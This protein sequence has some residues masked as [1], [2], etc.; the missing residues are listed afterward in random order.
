[1]IHKPGVEEVPGYYGLVKIE[2][3]VLQ[4]IWMEQDFFTDSLNTECGKEINLR[5][6]GEWNRSERGPSFKNARVEINGE[7]RSGDIEIHFHPTEWEE[8]EH[9]LDENF[10]RVVLHV[11]IFANSL[12]AKSNVWRKDKQAV[13][14]LYLLPYLFYGL[15]EYAEAQAL[16]QLS[17][18]D[19]FVEQMV[20]NLSLMSES[21]VNQC[22]AK[23]WKSKLSFARYRLSR[24]GWRMACHQWFLEVLGYRGNRAPMVR[25]SHQFPFENWQDLKMAPRSVYHSQNDWVL[26]GCRPANHPRQRIVEYTRLW[27]LNP[28]WMDDLKNIPQKFNNL[29]VWSENDRKEILKLANYWRSTILQDIF[30]RGKAN[31]LWIDFALP[32]LC[33]N[34]Q[35]NGYNIWKNWPSGDC[36]QSYRKWAGSIG[37]TDRERKKTFTNGLVQCIIGTCSV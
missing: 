25:V 10:N 28:N 9:H 32:L 13:P 23:R 37:W 5:E 6:R 15:E 1:M 16:A 7:I 29:A 4:R 36:P 21:D 26:R 31:T 30:G 14:C 3:T 17:G 34:F 11:C 2:E 19:L 27:E 33:E 20:N 22:I 8:H 18:K 35:I 24:Q 12:N